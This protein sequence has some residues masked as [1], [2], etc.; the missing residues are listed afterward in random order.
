MG[1]LIDKIMTM[2]DEKQVDEKWEEILA[3]P[4]AVEENMGELWVCYHTQLLAIQSPKFP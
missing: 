1:T 4:E 3:E 2:D